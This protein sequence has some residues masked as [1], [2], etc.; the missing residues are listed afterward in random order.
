MV[1]IFSNYDYSYLGNRNDDWVF[2]SAPTYVLS[3]PQWLC[4]LK[5][6]GWC[7]AACAEM[8]AKNFIT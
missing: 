6:Y 4:T 7:W 1:Q 3:L 5:D 2:E 8:A